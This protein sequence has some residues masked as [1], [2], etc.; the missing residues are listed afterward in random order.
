MSQVIYTKATSDSDLLKIL[1][2][3]R[4]NLPQNLDEEM[5]SKEGFVTVEHDIELLR[6]MNQPFQHIIA[7]A[8][9]SLVGYALVMEQKWRDRIEV[10]VPMFAEIDKVMR[11]RGLSEESYFVM[12]QVCVDVDF[13]GK[14][15]FR[16]QYDCLKESMSSH[17]RYCITEIAA[18]NIRS[19][20]AHLSVGFVEFHRYQ[21]KSETE[22]V[23]VILEY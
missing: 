1:E 18:D 16:G 6:Q 3:Q 8:D 17:F 23:L 21:D 5:M 7:K 12:G 15:V 2:L 11:S 22:W 14:G 19:M 20:N 4:K 10:L 9:G 13:R